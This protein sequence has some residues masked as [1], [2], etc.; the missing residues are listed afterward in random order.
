MRRSAAR[1]VLG[2]LEQSKKEYVTASAKSRRIAR[3]SGVVKLF[4]PS[5]DEG[6]RIECQEEQ[7]AG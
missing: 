2:R 7:N 1:G 3:W 4:V 6:S 5:G